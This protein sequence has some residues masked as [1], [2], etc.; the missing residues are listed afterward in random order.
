LARMNHQIDIVDVSQLML[1]DA[2]A[3]AALAGVS[4]RI[5]THAS[6]I[7][8]IGKLFDQVKFD[9]VL[10]HNVIQY[11]D[12]LEPLFD[13]MDKVLKIGG[14]LSLIGPNQYSLP[15]QAAFLNGDLD[16]AYKLL[17]QSEQISSIF[18]VNERAYRA[19][20]L[21]DW[22]DQRGYRLENH[23]G[24]RCMYNYWGTNEKKQQA[25]IYEKLKKLE[26]ALTDRE[27]YKQTARLFQLIL[28]KN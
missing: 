8:N 12:E 25:G 4:G 22:L 14:I 24:I 23:Y 21:I 11:V 10:C 18:G 5:T 2:N 3:N 15:Y 17:D 1:N 7:L 26:F 6:D 16:E 19:D 28:R 27:P 20:E 13:A 9:M